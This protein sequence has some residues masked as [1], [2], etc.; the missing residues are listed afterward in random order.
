[1]GKYKKMYTDDQRKQF[2]ADLLKKRQDK[3]RK[4]FEYLTNADGFTFRTEFIK[5]QAKEICKYYDRLQFTP[6]KSWEA[7]LRDIVVDEEFMNKFYLTIND[8]GQLVPDDER[9]EA[10]AIKSIT[11][12]ELAHQMLKRNT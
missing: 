12:E 4:E 5:A 10:L 7:E 2:E 11:A 8:Y 3:I 9:I 1:M 6:F